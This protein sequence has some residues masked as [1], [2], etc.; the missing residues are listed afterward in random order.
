MAAS[1]NNVNLIDF[2]LGQL[3]SI[4]LVM[5][6]VPHSALKS[7]HSENSSCKI[8][9]PACPRHEKLLRLSLKCQAKFAHCEIC[10]RRLANLGGNLTDEKFTFL[11][12]CA[13]Q[14]P[15]CFSFGFLRTSSRRTR[16][17]LP[18]K[19]IV[20]PATP[21][22]VGKFQANSGVT[23]NHGNHGSPSQRACRLLRT[24]CFSATTN[25]RISP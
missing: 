20:H 1:S 2:D 12:G 17:A 24:R 21:L 16:T 22:P 3:S 11:T 19:S 18:S 6:K 10:H 8:T 13:E 23:T 5:E 14:H 7:S 15:Y 4:V 25:P 9:A